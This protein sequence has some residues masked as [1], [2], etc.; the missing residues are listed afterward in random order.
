MN[1]QKV[2]HAHIEAVL[3]DAIAD[4]MDKLCAEYG[5]DM[6]EWYYPFDA[7][8]ESAFA[9]FAEAVANAIEQTVSWYTDDEE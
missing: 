5:I 8:A 1:R 9:D 4:A 2:D 6:I 7:D 3:N